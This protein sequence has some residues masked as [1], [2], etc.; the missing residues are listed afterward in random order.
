VNFAL[1]SGGATD[2]SDGRASHPPAGDLDSSPLSATPA[3]HGSNAPISVIDRLTALPQN[4][5]FRFRYSDKR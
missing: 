2:I 4:W 5:T 3:S 1:C